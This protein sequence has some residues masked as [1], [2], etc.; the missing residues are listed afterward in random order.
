MARV[1]MLMDLTR[2]LLEFLIKLKW[3]TSRPYFL[4]TR[5]AGKRRMKKVLYTF[6]VGNELG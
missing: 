2:V 3:I 6:S 5:N 1:R 4:P